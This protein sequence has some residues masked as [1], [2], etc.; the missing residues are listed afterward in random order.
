MTLH[1]VFSPVDDTQLLEYLTNRHE[2]RMLV[3]HCSLLWPVATIPEMLTVK[4]M[5]SKL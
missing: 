4:T 1:W 5:D 2:T 3:S